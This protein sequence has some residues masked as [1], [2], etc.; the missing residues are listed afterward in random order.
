MTE[1][2]IL[3]SNCVLFG[4]V[5]TAWTSESLQELQALLQENASL[6]FLRC[7]LTD[8]PS[9]LPIL[10]STEISPFVSRLEQFQELADFASGKS[11]PD[12]TALSNVHLAPLTV[13]YQAVEFIRLAGLL[14]RV[15]PSQSTQTSCSLPK[16]QGVQGFCLGFLSAAAIASSKDWEAFE[17]NFA[18]SIRL[19][20]CIGAVIEGD[21]RSRTDGLKSL[22][23]R[24]KTDKARMQADTC[25]D[26]FSDAFVSCITDE[27]S[28]TVTVPEDDVPKYTEQLGQIGVTAKEIGLNGAYHSKR[29]TEVVEAFIRAVE[30]KNNLQLRYRDSLVYPLRSNANAQMI[31]TEPLH[32]VAFRTILCNRAH[33]YQV[34]KN[35]VNSVKGTTINLLPI[36]KGSFVPRAM[37]T[38]RN[39]SLLSQA[40]VS[41][42]DPDDRWTDEIAIVGMSCRYPSADS[43]SDFWDLLCE[44][45]T[46]I[47]KISPARFNPADCKDRAKNLEY[48]GNF[49]SDDVVSTFDH[50]FFGLSA[51]EAKSMDPQQRIALQVAYEALE[52]SGY[53]R[54]S[55]RPED[56]GCY[57]GVLSVDY[58][59]NVE[60][61]DATA[62]SAL[63]TLRAFV[64]GR[65]SH[66]F[67]LTGPSVTVDTA[68]SSAAVAIHT[69]CQS[70]LAKDCSMALA[71]GVNVITSP[72]MFQNLAGASFLSPTG[73]SKAFDAS[74][75]GYCRGEG[76]GILVLK[77]LS[78][79]LADRDLVLGVIAGSAVNQGANCSA[80]QVPHSGSQY[81]LYQQSLARSG[82]NATDVTYVEAHG[83][84]TPVGDPIEYE[85]VK[86]TFEDPDSQNDLYLGSVKDN[87]GHTESASGV[88]GLIKCLLMM[89]HGIIP[90]QAGFSRLNPKINPSKRIVIP[91][92]NLN[93]QG[94]HVALVANY[95]AA[96]SNAALV[97]RESN[98][99]SGQSTSSSNQAYPLLLSAKSEE[100]L[101]LYITALRRW[102]SGTKE[103]FANAAFNIA[104]KQNTDFL[105]RIAITAT[106]N[107]ELTE[108]LKTI[109]SAG[110]RVVANNRQPVILC[111]GGQNGRTVTLSKA[112]Y[113][114]SKLL[115]TYIDQCDVACRS[116]GLDSIF[117][118]VFENTP[119]DDITALHCMLFSVQYATAMTWIDSGVE[120][121][122][123]LGHSFGQLT[124]LTV[125]GAISLKDGLRL[126]SGRARLLQEKCS[127]ES[128]QMISLECDIK[129]LDLIIKSVNSKADSHVEV[130]CYNGPS[131]FVVGG[132]ELSTKT[133]E[134]ECAVLGVKT[135][136]L[137]NTHAYHTHII[138]KTI[139]E[140]K[141]LAKSISF[142]QPNIRVE[143]CSEGS[144]WSTVTAELIA[145]HSRQPVYFNDAV[146]RIHQKSKSAIWLEAGTGSFIVPMA[147]RALPA[148][149]KTE[150]VFL[151]LNLGSE[152]ALAN[153]AEATC[154]LWRAG[155]SAQFWQFHK[156]QQGDW[157]YM[158][159]PHY[160]FERPRHWIEYKQSARGAKLATMTETAYPTSS[161][162][163][164]TA[165]SLNA[166]SATFEVNTSHFTFQLAVNGHV[167]GGQSICPASTYV[168]IAAAAIKS[169]TGNKAQQW[170][171][172]V[173]D[174]F[175]RT[176]FQSG[177]T[178]SLHVTLTKKH[179]RAW[180]FRVFSGHKASGASVHAGGL[181]K[182][183]SAQDPITE[184]RLRLIKRLTGYNA[185]GHFEG[186]RA[187]SVS[188]PM[189]YELLANIIDYAPYYR[190]VNS[191]TASG[192][193][194]LGTVSLSQ[195]GFLKTDTLACDAIALENFLLVPSIQLNCLARSRSEKGRFACVHVEE[196]VFSAAFISERKNNQSWTVYSKHEI[197]DK[198]TFVADIFVYDSKSREVAVVIMGATFQ[199]VQQKAHNVASAISKQAKLESLDLPRDLNEIYSDEESPLE[200]VVDEQEQALRPVASQSPTLGRLQ[201]MLAEVMEISPSEISPTSTFDEIG[202][203]SLMVTEV[204][205]ETNKRFN[206]T[207][208]PADFHELADVRSLCV[209]ID[210]EEDHSQ[211]TQGEK[212]ST[213]SSFAEVC[214]KKFLK[215][216][217]ITKQV[218]ETGFTNF[219]RDIF[220]LQMDLVIAYIVEAF[221]SLGC[222]PAE[223]QEGEKAK[224]FEFVPQHKKLVAE[225]YD[226]LIEYGIFTSDDDSYIRTAKPTPT[227]SAL[228]LHERLSKFSVH[229]SETKL[230][231]CT[232]HRLGDCLSGAADP[233]ALLFK[234]AGS[235]ALWENVYTDSPIFK[236]C[237][238]LFA[239]YLVD[240]V[241]GMAPGQE[242]RILELGAGT[243]GTTKHLVERLA[244][245]GRNFTYTFTDLSP[246]LVAAARRRFSKY[247]FMKFE[248]INME[249]EPEKKFHG[250]FDIIFGAS[251]IHATRNLVE[252]T[253]NIRKMLQPSGIVCLLELTRNLPWFSLVFGLLEGWWLFEDNRK[254]VLVPETHW[255]GELRKAGYQFVDW[256]S[257]LHKESEIYRVIVASPASMV[258]GYATTP[259][260]T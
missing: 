105:H 194:A 147:R 112:V 228:A 148:A 61:E 90:K 85:S 162:L 196:I 153:L 232:A 20:A 24:W 237:N 143:T 173:H 91:Q 11:I 200:T 199:A 233:I 96:G 188:G 227:E 236:M 45:K 107:E 216:R 139:P 222:S 146:Q 117:P 142:R 86:M 243:G 160:Q 201:E 50:K 231:H 75:N 179:D 129:D 211:E 191:I 184:E 202:I 207:V 136:A 182:L 58:E 245:T 215:N 92:N 121:D 51:R 99:K 225:L 226:I 140:L 66:Q 27:K 80:I 60:S 110:S 157:K 190:G 62:F 46:G 125:A 132:K 100:S 104:R 68:C 35:G 87:V 212:L 120:V 193:N 88:A 22:S 37:A 152:S 134:E 208:T 8:L 246:S 113:E 258:E 176:P 64:S 114:S 252:S 221:A 175:I 28:V 174:L 218:E 187:S 248:V 54:N 42:I 244:A 94:P 165:G 209:L 44:G 256:S 185:A 79:A 251:C 240:V 10:Q 238:L 73:A 57:L 223:L 101:S 41:Q 59:D 39:I 33:W 214:Q 219:F 249:K 14:G 206:T 108:K 154:E 34:V 15:P 149:A 137:E 178:D 56:V 220:P 18:T 9:I 84:G 234:N 145:S 82:M 183:V 198:N 159:V 169:A 48:W 116:L 130:A 106:S 4:P 230:L 83:T 195:N 111:F 26:L 168:E 247:P 151:P 167:V 210:G 144:A 189:V 77:R 16:L 115:K 235:R 65:L 102:L 254:H 78:T 141:A 239:E 171:P 181:I 260:E 12:P 23:I 229:E 1:A 124:A 31:G 98:S 72:S 36:G 192:Y 49:L 93:W 47:G 55:H 126:I 89:E 259:V 138:E 131:S 97:V 213:Q 40:E 70:L 205:A 127:A 74:S 63:G 119:V 5:V 123:L 52:S 38:R 170:L 177:S 29:H 67:G 203:D 69:A 197:G 43:P 133:L 250:A 19:A 253:T 81:K 103:P 128:G 32:E 150:N 166:E 71:G 25:L 17:Q 76:A 13:A 164:A 204:I 241:Q 224:P 163:K 109:S 30:V 21:L 6:V 118:G 180:D 155:S 186:A 95:G 158:S 122:T 2:H 7:A 3:E 242:I 217:S 53:Y 172:R 257:S 255:Q 156:S 161:L 135:R